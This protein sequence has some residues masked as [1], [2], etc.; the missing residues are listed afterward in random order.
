VSRIFDENR[1]VF[2]L[3]R[4]FNQELHHFTD[5]RLTRLEGVSSFRITSVFSGTTS[6]C[7][8]AAIGAV[9]PRKRERAAAAARKILFFIKDSSNEI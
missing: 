9:S 2:C 7:A 4:F 3:H 8:Q 5:R 6:D 1:A